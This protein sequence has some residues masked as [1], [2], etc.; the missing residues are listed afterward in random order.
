MRIFNTDTKEVTDIVC[1]E[2]DVAFVTAMIRQ[3]C[4]GKIVR[5]SLNKLNNHYTVWMHFKKTLLQPASVYG[6]SENPR[7]LFLAD[8]AELELVTCVK[9]KERK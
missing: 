6:F 8:R 9:N 7:E 1:F 2:K 4:E 3:V 5:I